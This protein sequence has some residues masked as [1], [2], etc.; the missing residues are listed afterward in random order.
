MQCPFC[1]S[2][3]SPDA[4]VCEKCGAT[5]VT[6]R[7]PAGIFVGWVGMVLALI[8]A[9]LWIPLLILPFTERGLSGYPWLVLIVGTIVAAGLLWYSKSTVHSKWVRRED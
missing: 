3:I 9:M 5:R 8:W 1:A 2:E 7:T 4:V 6:Q